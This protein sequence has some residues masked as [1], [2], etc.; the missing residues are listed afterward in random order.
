MPVDKMFQSEMSLPLIRRTDRGRHDANGNLDNNM[1]QLQHKRLQLPK[2]TT[3][4]KEKK[5]SNSRL[6]NQ[7]ISG[8]RVLNFHYKFINS[9]IT[10]QLDEFQKAW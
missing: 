2:E 4:K 10:Y 8:H 9:L 6:K 7:E 3:E 5:D 1:Q